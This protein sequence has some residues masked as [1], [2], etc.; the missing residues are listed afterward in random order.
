MERI[1]D[2]HLKK[3]REKIEINGGI[4]LGIN[5]RQLKSKLLLLLKPTR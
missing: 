3:E 4:S 5:L 2:H 1:L